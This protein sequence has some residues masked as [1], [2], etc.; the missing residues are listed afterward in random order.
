MADKLGFDLVQQTIGDGDLLFSAPCKQ[1]LV[2]GFLQGLTVGRYPIATTGQF[3]QNIRNNLPV[4]T[5]DKT[6]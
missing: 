2:D 5:G 1:P 3:F 6:D 4:G